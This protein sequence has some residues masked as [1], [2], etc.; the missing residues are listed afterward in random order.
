MISQKCTESIGPE[1]V[2]GHREADTSR[3]D[4]VCTMT[5][6]VCTLYKTGG[7]GGTGRAPNQ[8]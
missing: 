8:C 7:G 2:P 6:L 5:S 3:G 1:E 4:W